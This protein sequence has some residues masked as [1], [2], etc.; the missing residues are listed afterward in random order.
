MVLAALVYGLGLSCSVGAA[1]L[2][3][4]GVELGRMSVWRDAQVAGEALRRRRPAGSVRVLG[5][6]ET[7]Y[8]VRGEGG[9][10]R[11]RG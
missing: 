5:A 6:A 11:V 4:L 1:F 7:V 2:R 3:A 8:R 10:G 9:P